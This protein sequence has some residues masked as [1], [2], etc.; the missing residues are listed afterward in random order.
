MKNSDMKNQN[1][2]S[3]LE[4][5]IFR[6]SENELTAGER[7]ELEKKLKQHPELEKVYYDL[8]HLPDISKAY[9]HHMLSGKKMDRRV[10]QLLNTIEKLEPSPKSFENLSLH[11][12]KRYALAASVLFLALTSGFYFSQNV[13]AESDLTV[14]ELLYPMEESETETYVYYLEQLFE[15]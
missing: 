9:D 11:Y 1:S 15:Q 12:F 3:Q 8:I 4:M 7:E 10:N 14:E 13:P 6:A 2:I 5:E